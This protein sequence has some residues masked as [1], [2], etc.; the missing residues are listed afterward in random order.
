MTPY[1]VVTHSLT[2]SLTHPQE[3]RKNT[4]G[5]LEFAAMFDQLKSTLNILVFTRI[6]LSSGPVTP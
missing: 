3:T 2:H 6:C 5:F 1:G 4:N